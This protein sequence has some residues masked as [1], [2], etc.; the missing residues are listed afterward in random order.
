LKSTV[1]ERWKAIFNRSQMDRELDEEMRYFLER[2]IE[3]NL[4]RGLDPEEARRLAYRDFGGVERFQQQAREERGVGLLSD[5][6]RDV[7]HS[8]R[9]LARTPALTATIVLTVGLGIGATTAIFS[10]INAVLLAPLPYP[11]SEQLVYIRTT[12]ASN[13]YPLSVVDYLALTE[14]QTSFQHITAYQNTTMT[15]VHN[16]G[17][18][19]VRGKS[20][21]WT[22]FP[23]LGIKPLHGRT[24]NESDNL[25]GAEGRVVVSHGFWTRFLDA[26]GTAIGR[27]IRLD[28]GDYVVVGVLPRETGTLEQQREVFTALQMAAPT[29]KGPFGLIVLGRL[30]PDVDVSAA[31]EEL[32][33]IPRRIFPIWQSSYQ[34]ESAIWAMLDLKEAVVGDVGVT[35]LIVLGAV[36]FVLLIASTNAANLLLARI[37]HRNRELAVRAALGASRGRLLRHLLSESLLLAV[38]SALAG[39]ALALAGVRLLTAVG[40][41]YIPRTPEIGLDAPVFWFLAMITVASGLMFGLIPALQGARFR[42]RQVLS[43]GGRS[44]TDAIG[45][46]RLRHALVVAQFAI[47]APLLIGAGLLLGSLARLQRVDPGIDTRNLLSFSAFL[48]AA[49]Y[50]DSST[51]GP[52][53]DEALSRIRALP[54]VQGATLGS[55]RPPGDLPVTN[56]FNLEDKPTPPDQSQPDVPWVSIMPEYFETLGIPLLEGRTFDDQDRTGAPPVA[57]VDQAWATRFFPEGGAVGRRFRSGGSTTDPWTTVVGVV[58]DVKYTGLESMDEG[59]IYVTRLGGTYRFGYFLVRTAADPMSI[60]PAVKNVMQDLGPTI[61]LADMATIDGLVGSS[62]DSQR[63]LTLLVSLFAVASLVLSVIGIY[64]VMANFVQRHTR[65]IGIRIALGGR[66]SMVVR[67]VVGRGVRL[68]GIGIAIGLVGALILTRSMR[69][70]LFGVSPTDPL[71]FFGVP[72]VMLVVVLLAC[73]VPAGRAAGVDPARTL[74]VE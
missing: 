42:F 69:S 39:T 53:W 12:S 21:T 54:G 59:T 9:C 19:R 74:R 73:L 11:D 4:A 65:D 44:A 36:A 50:P 48:P 45:P 56:N 26:D 2:S 38:G 5:L 22:Y 49:T 16:D 7:R 32:Q 27:T 10:V 64:G 13:S 40:V 35:L 43:A 28:G 34:D 8:L 41:G 15:L 68:V 66:P 63:Y 30:K 60:L 71:T 25:A 57:V 20:V 18:E 52:F 62:L 33:A 23:L 55:A 51:V 3:R 24:L 46:R 29:R 6:I 70:L 14:Q 72:A 67:A 61:P 47:V 17:P 1:R 31:A 58:G 37:T